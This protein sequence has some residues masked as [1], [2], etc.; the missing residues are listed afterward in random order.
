MSNPFQPGDWALHKSNQLD[1]REVASVDGDTIQL[2]IGDRLTPP[3]RAANYDRVRTADGTV[4]PG[5]RVVAYADEGIFDDSRKH[6]MV[7]FVTEG[8]PGYNGSTYTG[9]LRY[10]TAVAN[11]INE[12]RGFT[13]DQVLDVVTS[14]FAAQSAVEDF[15]DG[16]SRYDGPAVDITVRERS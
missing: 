12:S 6:H 2:R 13:P 14:S 5:P 4:M 9:D 7:A 1:A 11:S 15:V 16:G 10:C 3:V 8:E